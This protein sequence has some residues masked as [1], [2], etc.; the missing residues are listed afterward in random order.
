MAD[1]K[2]LEALRLRADSKDTLLTS[3]QVANLCGAGHQTVKDWRVAGK[4]K[5]AA[6]DGAWYLYSSA[7]L[8]AILRTAIG[9]GYADALLSASKRKGKA[10]KKK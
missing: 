5:P 6:K 4:L 10:A 9:G 1:L 7:D 2:D 3:T 8:A